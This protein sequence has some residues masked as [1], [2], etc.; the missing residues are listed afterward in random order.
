VLCV[1][2]LCLGVL[3][4]F[5]VWVCCLCAVGGYVVFVGVV[6]VCVVSAD[7]NLYYFLFC[8]VV[9]GFSLF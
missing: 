8:S 9:F 7:L 5:C 1:C 6:C 3:F 2:V 4:V